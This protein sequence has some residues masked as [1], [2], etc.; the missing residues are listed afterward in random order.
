MEENQ[1]LKMYLDKIMKDYRALQMQF[2]DTIVQQE[3]NKPSSGTSVITTTTHNHHQEEIDQESDDQFVSLSL[4]RTTNSSSTDHH[5]HVKKDDSSKD[6]QL[7]LG[8]DCKLELPSNEHVSP[9]PSPEASSEEVKEDTN[10]G[11]QKG[12]KTMRTDDEV[13]QQNPAKR[14]RVSVRVR[15]DTPT[16][17]EKNLFGVNSLYIFHVLLIGAYL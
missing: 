8:L 7:T 15:C 12:T 1:R 3:I 14:A 11:D 13:S 5:H 6:G 16:V 17:R 10:A 9:N 2:R 4:G